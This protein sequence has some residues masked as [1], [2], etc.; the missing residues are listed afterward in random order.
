MQLD[1][2]QHGHGT[3]K[4][5]MDPSEHQTEKQRPVLSSDSSFNR[6][7]PIGQ[8]GIRQLPL[9]SPKANPNP[10]NDALLQSPH[11]N[12]PGLLPTMRSSNVPAAESQ[13]ASLE[14]E[15]WR[16]RFLPAR[17][18]T[19]S[20]L[21]EI[22]RNTDLSL[23]ERTAR[24]DER[25]H[26][27]LSA[28]EYAAMWSE[29]VEADAGANL[30]PYTHIGNVGGDSADADGAWETREVI[31]LVRMWPDKHIPLKNK[32]IDM[33]GLSGNERSLSSMESKFRQIT[34]KPQ[35]IHDDLK[36]E[37]VELDAHS[38]IRKG[39][40][41]KELGAGAWLRLEDNTLRRIHRSSPS[42]DWNK[43]SVEWQAITGRKRSPH[44]LIGR[45]GILKVAHDPWSELVL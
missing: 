30:W 25:L 24:L 35:Y 33:M 4:A 5:N 39:Q 32:S 28:A 36:R 13:D 31:F 14:V 15:D 18:T 38:P 34:G 22:W 45:W 6:K 16:P 27:T 41:A 17:A 9:P 2:F 12:Q 42:V 7:F 20:A 37:Q 19:N 10:S 8:D 43:K 3:L 44:E 21:R 40:N 29:I 11:H 1:T 23:K 26:V